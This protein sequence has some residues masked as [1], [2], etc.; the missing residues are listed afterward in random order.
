MP[1]RRGVLKRALGRGAENMGTSAL[2]RDNWIEQT[3]GVFS[4]GLN[5]LSAVWLGSIAILILCD[6]IGREF[7]QS[8][9][10]GTNEIV[11]NSVVSILFL[12]LP[13]TIL[14]RSSL[15][16][17]IFYGVAGTRGRGFIDAVSYFL[18]GLLFLAIAVGSWPNMVE[19]WEILEQE[20]S[21]IITIPVYPIRT[22]VVF[23]SFVGVIV[24]GLLVYQSL[25]KPELYEESIAASEPNEGD[26]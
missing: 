12:Q 26:A 25:R 13:L 15:R 2:N 11:S 21:G 20:G 1:W 16:T 5:I 14:T 4:R 9:V 3:V 22:L 10:Y 17:T 23:V 7:F 6:V 24:S 8:P 19:A 18:A